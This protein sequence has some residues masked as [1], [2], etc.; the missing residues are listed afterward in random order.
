MPWFIRH[1]P[2]RFTELIFSTDVHLRFLQWLR[3]ARHG[4][5]LHLSGPSGSGK[6]TLVRA[7]AGALGYCVVEITDEM[8]V[9]IEEHVRHRGTALDG[10]PRLLVVDEIAAQGLALLLRSAKNAAVPLVI[11]SS[12]LRTHSIQLLKVERPTTD[13][14]HGV[15]HGIGKA[16]G[17]SVDARLI[18]KIAEQCDHDMRA[19]INYAQLLRNAAPAACGRLSTERLV[20]PSIF[21]TCM[22]VSKRRM[23]LAELE[24]MHDAKVARLCLGSL[25]AACRD[26]ALTARALQRCSEIATLPHHY[27]FLELDQMN[28]WR[29]EFVYQHDEYPECRRWRRADDPAH[30][31]SLYTRS[32]G[33]ASALQH[34]REML[35]RCRPE[36]LGECD[37]KILESADAALPAAP[38]VFRYRHCAG[39]TNAVK[40]DISLREILEL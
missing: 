22:Q 38:K 7:A 34:L 26:P 19:V 1:H 18:G 11:T 16:E 14:I 10:R 32:P 2:R 12:T 27:E 31:L 3:G 15:L 20:H 5:V 21:Y 33:G 24:R 30:F 36:E 40:R 9:D 25:L 39:S 13:G 28:Q 6:T 29:G 17:L 4:G 35:G 8:L 23:R 37:R